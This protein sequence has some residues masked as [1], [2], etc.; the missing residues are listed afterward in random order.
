MERV[1]ES[2]IGRMMIERNWVG[3]ADY[4]GRWFEVPAP[5]AEDLVVWLVGYS[6]WSHEA[7]GFE[8]MARAATYRLTSDWIIVLKRFMEPYI[9][10][11]TRHKPPEEI[12]LGVDLHFFFTQIEETP[13]M[14]DRLWN[15]LPRMTSR[16]NGLADRR[17][18]ELF[19]VPSR[20]KISKTQLAQ[21]NPINATAARV[22]P[23]FDNGDRHDRTDTP[24]QVD[25]P[26]ERPRRRDA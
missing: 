19:G 22:A 17:Y 3:L 6:P 21:L 24:V 12:R 20:S 2:E 11:A 8:W 23:E 18:E 4:L 10:A 5:P 7:N 13:E 26:D 1:P 16:L 25:G 14:Y 9:E 15:E